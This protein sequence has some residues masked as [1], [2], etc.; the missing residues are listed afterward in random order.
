METKN[1]IDAYIAFIDILGFKKI[2]EQS[3]C[4]NIYSIFATKFRSQLSTAHL[5]G[6][7]VFDYKL[8]QMK[9]MS[10]SICFFVDA[11]VSNSLMG[12]VSTCLFFQKQ[13]LEMDTPIL[14]RGAIVR[15]DIFVED[16]IVFGPGFVKAYLLEEK[17]AKTP[18]I[19]MTKEVIDGAKENTT[20]IAKNFVVGTT[21]RDDDAY[22]V[23]N[24]F[25]PLKREEPDKYTAHLM[26]HINHVLDT[27]T[28]SSVREKYIYLHKNIMRW[29]AHLHV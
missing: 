15:G 3:S 27:I 12:L 24:Y 8:V 1:Y 10:D 16:D 19:I 17:N 23:V 14:T 20:P 22:Y 7:L 11:K 2:V 29:N 18:R 13:L 9:V 4:S 25:E 5:E 6:N 21:F 28:D 26:E